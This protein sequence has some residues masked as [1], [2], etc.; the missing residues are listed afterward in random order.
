MGSD[1]IENTSIALDCEIV[2]VPLVRVGSGKTHAELLA[3]LDE[4]S[5]QIA[6]V[7]VSGLIVT[8]NSA[9]RAFAVANG[10]HDPRCG[11]GTNYLETCDR[12]AATGCED[13]RVVAAGIRAIAAGRQMTFHHEYPGDTPTESRR[14]IVSI[15]KLRDDR[16]GRIVIAHKA[17]STD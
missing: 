17:V 1:M 13:A 15:S 16:M 2:S 4:F 9:W 7:S 5:S 10:M 6:L 11:L 3:T 12:A 8:V 14:F